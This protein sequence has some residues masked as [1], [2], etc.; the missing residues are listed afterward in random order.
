M[1]K[2]I[3]ILLLYSTIISAQ[4]Q[5]KNSYNVVYSMKNQEN[6]VFAFKLI[7]FD[8]M[9]KYFSL[10]SI[11]NLD[12]NFEALPIKNTN[13][14]KADNTIIYAEKILG[15]TILVKDSLNIF[16]WKLTN[17]T[18]KI[19]NY[20]C[21]SAITKFRGREYKAFYTSEI[22]ISDGPWKFSG[23]PGLILKIES[24]DGD[25]IYEAISIKRI[26]VQGNNVD[27][28]EYKNTLEKEFLSWHN[29]ENLFVK[30]M[31]EYVKNMKASQSIEEAKYPNYFKYSRPEII[32]KD[33]QTGDGIEY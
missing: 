9:S 2:I 22:F 7:L 32:Y 11:E 14:F 13:L 26:I 1:K 8:S 19:L 18:K 25:Y 16:N 28:F 4:S 6:K 10:G 33:L 3:A 30:K 5:Q 29:F 21:N 12:R 15:E 20:N 17:E 24:L 23:L 27:D 31:K